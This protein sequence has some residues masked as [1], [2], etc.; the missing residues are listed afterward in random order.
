[1]KVEVSRSDDETRFALGDPLVDSYLEFVAGRARPN[2]LRAVAFDLKYFFTVVKEEPTDVVA[3]DIFEFLAN[4]KVE[5]RQVPP[6]IMTGS[7]TD[8]WNLPSPQERAAT[9]DYP[10]PDHSVMAEALGQVH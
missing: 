6:V 10:Y 3:A 2:T 1:V 7:C 8:R 5:G 4:R 9:F